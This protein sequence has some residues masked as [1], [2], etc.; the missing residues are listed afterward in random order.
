[1]IQKIAE[2]SLGAV[3]PLV[4]GVAAACQ[5]QASANVEASAAA[6]IDIAIPDFLALISASLAFN[7]DAH[8]ALAALDPA[9][10]VNVNAS[11]S[12]NVSAQAALELA[13]ALLDAL[14]ANV[15]AYIYAGPSD[16]VSAEVGAAAGG[17]GGLRAGVLLAAASPA[18]MVTVST[19]FGAESKA[20]ALAG[21][22]VRV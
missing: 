14:G 12:V 10:L 7:A 22:S 2:G 15:A 5:A 6:S 17:S 11:A 16:Q 8:A 18:A 19:L 4:A 21:A 9:S 1:M 13:I 3:M 20:K